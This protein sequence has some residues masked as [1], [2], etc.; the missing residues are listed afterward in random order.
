MADVNCYGSLISTRHTTVPLLNTAQTEA[1]QEETKTD[2]NFVGSQQ[3]AGTFASQQ[4]GQFVLAKAGIV[5]ENDMTYAFIMSAG[6]IKAALPMGSGI[7]G[8]SQGLP[9][10]IPYPKQLLPGDSVQTMVNAVSDRQAAVSV[11]CTS[12]EYHVF[13]VTASG[14]GEHEFTSVLDGQGIGTTL[15]GR[16][17]S[18]W[19]ALS[20][21]NDAELTSPVYLLDGSGVPTDSVSFTSSGGAKA[22]VFQPTQARVALNSRLVYRTDA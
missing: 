20:G 21:N 7:A 5:A 19:F 9:A 13:E 2:S 8:G 10:P 16:I 15:Q 14:S 17:I 6:K 11:A 1:S 4:F 22:A 3:T 12:G 18:H